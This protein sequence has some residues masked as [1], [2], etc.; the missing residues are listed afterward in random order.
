MKSR[1]IKSQDVDEGEKEVLEKDES[2]HEEEEEEKRED[3]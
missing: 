1:R 3:S 2:D